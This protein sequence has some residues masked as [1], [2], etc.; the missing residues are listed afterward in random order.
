MTLPAKPA[1]TM[2]R[3]SLTTTLSED[4][5]KRQSVG[6]KQPLDVLFVSAKRGVG[7]SS[8]VR[9]LSG[10]P[11]L[12]QHWPTVATNIVTVYKFIGSGPAEQESGEG[13]GKSL[14][15]T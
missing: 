8:L 15:T 7:Q 11:F 13:D 2:V 3:R 9:A 6:K 1:G 12:Q 14:V 5:A 10:E 4:L